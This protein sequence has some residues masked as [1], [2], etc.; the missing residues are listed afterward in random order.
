LLFFELQIKSYDFSKIWIKSGFKLLF[1]LCF[2]S[3]RATWHVLIGWYRFGRICSEGRR[4]K[5]ETNAPDL[6]IPLRVSDLILASRSRSN[7]RGHRG[8]GSPWKHTDGE[9][10]RVWRPTTSCSGG[11][12]ALGKS[13]R[14]VGCC[15]E[16]GSKI[17]GVDFFLECCRD[18][19]RAA[20]GR[21]GL[22]RS[23]ASVSG[24]ES[25]REKGVR[26]CARSR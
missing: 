23:M 5:R 19:A 13:G 11:L 8:E 14:G 25:R 2:N 16:D 17:D 22:Q 20:S 3:D 10:R 12:L 21:G 26:G 6:R 24:W 1:E 18:P 9:V 4:T 7:G 15:G